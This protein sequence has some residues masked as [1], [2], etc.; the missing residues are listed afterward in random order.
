MKQ[1]L[2]AWGERY[3]YSPSLSQHLLS[4]LLWPLSALYC[5]GMRRRFH[6]VIPNDPGI[7][8]VSIG[9]L[10]VGGSGKTP[11]TTALAQKQLRPA[12]VLR[13]YGRRS[14]GLQLVSDGDRVLCDVACS[15]DE[16]MQYALTLPHAVVIVSEDRLEGIARAKSMGCHCVLLDDGYGKHFIR[17]LDIVI[18]VQTPNRFCL[19]SGPYRERLWEGKRAF[20]AQE[21]RDFKRHVTVNEGA[22]KMVLVTAIAR[23]QRLEPFLPPVIARHYFPDHHYFEEEELREILQSSGAEK[24]LVTYKDYVKIR[25]FNLPTALLELTLEI[26]DELSGEVERFI[27]S[28]DENK[29]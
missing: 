20:V 6:S 14:R 22:K 15:G 17:K 16:A 11:L 28:Y 25:T 3:F 8:V 26:G 12:I 29:N 1:S 19:P 13:G 7:A 18:A 2:I 21:G 27:R 10:T 23:P 24:L 9:N 4:C 5:F